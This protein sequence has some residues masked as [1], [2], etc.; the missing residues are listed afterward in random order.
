MTP[1]V[2]VT[3]RTQV[4]SLNTAPQAILDWWMATPTATLT[5]C[6]QAHGYTISWISTL[7]R[8]DLFQAALEARQNELWGEVKFTLKDRLEALAHASLQ[9]MLQLVPVTGDMADLKDAAETALKGMG[10]GKSAGSPVQ[11]NIFVGAV[12]KEDLAA[13]RE[14]MTLVGY[15]EAP[16]VPAPAPD[17]QV[18]T[19]DADYVSD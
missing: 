12:S 6:A 3:Q 7:M 18:N 11:N 13:A 17:K 10:I 14:R 9:R 2:P 15:T 5:Q 19:L 16:R 8:T 1:E 4:Q